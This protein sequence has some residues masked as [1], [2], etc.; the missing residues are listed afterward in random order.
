M[1]LLCFETVITSSR[2]V[3]AGSCLSGAFGWFSRLL[4][5][6]FADGNDVDMDL[7]LAFLLLVG[8]AGRRGKGERQGK[9]RRAHYLC[10]CLS[11]ESLLR[12]VGVLVGEE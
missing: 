2:S 7:P 4:L 3:L 12:G 11:Q 8:L 5:L 6:L 10:L 1:R 9:G